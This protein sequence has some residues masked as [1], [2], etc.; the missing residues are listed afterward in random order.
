MA[1]KYSITTQEHGGL[2]EHVK[3]LY[4][5]KDGTF[6]L[7]VDGLEDTSGLKSALEKERA[8]AK[9]YEKKVKA[10]DALGK[11][12]EEISEL[13][14]QLKQKEDLEKNPPKD[15]PKEEDKGKP[16]DE[17]NPF[18][19]LVKKVEEQLAAQQAEMAALR[20]E[21]AESNAL[22]KKRIRETSIR[23]AF[24]GYPDEQK[25][26]FTRLVDGE[27]DEEIAV[28]VKAVKE[29]FP[30]PSKTP[31]HVGGPTNPPRKKEE[32]E[33]E[34]IKLAKALAEKKVNSQ[35]AISDLL[36]K[37]KEEWHYGKSR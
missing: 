12:P 26:A 29:M 36:K 37:H 6:T 9:E 16:K 11:K 14:K 17:P 24:E 3:G 23:N 5:E 19:G 20:K 35:K 32:P 15:K 10:W 25:A 18:E 30:L 34:A 31:A 22:E 4:T 21:Q 27:T 28:S 8:A 7:A 13:L 1:L 2:E 33:S